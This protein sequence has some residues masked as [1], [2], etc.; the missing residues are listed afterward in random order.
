MNYF[1]N[2]KRRLSRGFTLLEL[3]VVIA[4]IGILSSVVIISLNSARKKSKDAALITQVKQ[5]QSL[6]NLEFSDNQSYTNLQPDT[7]FPDTPCNSSFAGNYAVQA[8][9]VCNEI[10][11]LSGSWG[12]WTSPYLFYA[13]NIGNLPDKYSLMVPLNSKDR[14][15]CLG[16]SGV[17]DTEDGD[18][19]VYDAVG[20]YDN[21]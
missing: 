20:C 4:I 12:M 2:K 16:N 10:V 18:G 17:S 1:G 3:L 13:G 5:F 8:R 11:S 21:P 7:L 14:L 19:G 15:Y 6:L 9:S